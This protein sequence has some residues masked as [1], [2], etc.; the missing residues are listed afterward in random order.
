MC[1][2]ESAPVPLS[3]MEHRSI[4]AVHALDSEIFEA[5]GELMERAS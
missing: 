5:K 1:L 2:F 3:G 4:R